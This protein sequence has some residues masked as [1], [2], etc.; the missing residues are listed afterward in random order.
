MEKSVIAVRVALPSNRRTTSDKLTDFGKEIEMGVAVAQNKRVLGN[1]GLMLKSDYEAGNFAPY[2]LKQSDIGQKES[3]I[4]ETAIK[5]NEELSAKLD[6][7]QSEIERL[8]AQ[9][10]AKSS[11]TKAKEVTDG[12]E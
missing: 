5:V 4:A 3:A 2:N 1:M 6:S 11:R 9:L 10:A 8:K 12:A 7:A